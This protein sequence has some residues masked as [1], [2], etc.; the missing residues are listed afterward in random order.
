MSTAPKLTPSSLTALMCARICHDLVSPIGALSAAIEV[1]DDEEN[2][3]MRDD[4]L[5]LIRLSSKQ[6]AAKLQFLRLAFGAGGS[7]P[8]VLGI[9]QL[10]SLTANMY[11]DGKSEIE[12]AMDGDSLPKQGARLLLNLIMQGVMAIPR[13][14]QLRIEGGVKG[15]ATTL[16]LT[17]SGPKARLNSDFALT[18]EG[19]APEGGFD[20]RNIQSFYAGMIARE[21]KGSVTAS[22]EGE[23]VTFRATLPS[24]PSAEG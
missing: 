9:E 19:R 23:T 3:E 7:A 13:G 12:W 17:A 6:A 15:E 1:L 5:D 16:V 11:G 2:T 22:A 20:G 8:G 18:L 10:Q 4:A 24:A 14:G 21:G